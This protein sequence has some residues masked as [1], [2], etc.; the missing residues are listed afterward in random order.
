MRQALNLEQLHHGSS[1]ISVNVTVLHQLLL[2][3][4]GLPQIHIGL[5]QDVEQRHCVLIVWRL[6]LL[7]Q[8][9]T[10]NILTQQSSSM[11]F[12]EGIRSLNLAVL[13]TDGLGSS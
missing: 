12:D 13:L 6:A 10:L 11:Q 3:A 7:Q 5:A 4:D 2:Q 9:H 8:P 1:H